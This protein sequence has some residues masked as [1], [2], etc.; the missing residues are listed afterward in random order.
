MVA[1]GSVTDPGGKPG[2]L[3]DPPSLAVE[4]IWTGGDCLGGKSSEKSPYA[5]PNRHQVLLYIL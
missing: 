5:N 1:A 2:D 4:T 3:P